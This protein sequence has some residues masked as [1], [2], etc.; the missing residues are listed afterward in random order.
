MSYQKKILLAKKI[1]LI[2]FLNSIPVKIRGFA[3]RTRDFSSKVNE[4]ENEI[5]R[6]P[7]P[8]KNKL[9]VLKSRVLFF[10]LEILKF[11]VFFCEEINP[12]D[13]ISSPRFARG[14][15]TS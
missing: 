8:R 9:E 1:L 10:R 13:I 3:S 12:R 15:K 14:F 4:D 6:I 11:R 2:F 5:S 7:L